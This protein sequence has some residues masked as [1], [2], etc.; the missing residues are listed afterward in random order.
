MTLRDWLPST[1]R[2]IVWPRSGGS[3][4]VLP[5][6]PAWQAAGPPRASLEAFRFEHG[7]QQHRVHLR[8]H[9]DGS[10]LVVV[11]ASRLA[12]VPATSL[13]DLRA[14]LRSGGRNAGAMEKRLW[15]E[16][17][18]TGTGRIRAWN[19]WESGARQADPVPDLPLVATLEVGS[20][21]DAGRH[22]RALFDLA[23]PHVVMRPMGAAH[24][25]AVVAG[26]RLAEDLGLIAG[27][28]APVSVL[29]EGDLADRL[30]AAGVDHLAV[31][32]AG[33]DAAAHDAVM[34]AGDHAALERF[35]SRAARLEVPLTGEFPLLDGTWAN[36]A[37]VLDE[38]GRL[39][40]QGITCWA[41]VAPPGGVADGP[42]PVAPQAL[43]QVATT[44]E[45]AADGAALSV[46][47]AA[48]VVAADVAAAIAR[49]PRT[50]GDFGVRVTLAGEILAP[51]G[52]SEPAGRLGQGAW[53]D[54]LASGPWQAFSRRARA[55]T[56]CDDCPGLALCA[57]DCPAA[58]EGWA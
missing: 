33:A 30:A 2:D 42:K 45:H 48:P 24:G 22:V 36:I 20:A 35:A 34:G 31:T 5:S 49:G 28:A 10:G 56:R 37:G 3:R 46:T 52:S 18:L 27:V 47:W 50:D 44:I 55:A 1:W 4:A 29:D 14:W 12:R 58:R 9:A 11:D 19:A 53:A 25:E 21:E 40:L 32:I 8:E 17:I 7:G 23:I 15:G 54:V 43:R 6:L 41:I 26:V 39:G 57:L 51:R 38:A 13:A 16:P